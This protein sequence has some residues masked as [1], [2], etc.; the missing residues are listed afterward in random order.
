MIS[1]DPLSSFGAVSCLAS[2]LVRLVVMRRQL[3]V[4]AVA[5]SVVLCAGAATMW[6]STAAVYPPSAAPTHAGPVQFRS[7]GGQMEFRWGSAWSRSKEFTFVFGNPTL[8]NACPWHALGFGLG[9]PGATGNQYRVVM[10][11]WFVMA[12]SAVLPAWS[13]ARGVRRYRRER[14]G[15]CPRCGYDRRATPDRCPE[16][17][18]R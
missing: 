12:A 5:L 1:G 6:L 4:A 17:G 3:L 16:C 14:D 10:P 15:L 18:A 13:A 9:V 7:A 11:H 2:H 8:S